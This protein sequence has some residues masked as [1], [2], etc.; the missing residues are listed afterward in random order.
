MPELDC[1]IGLGSNLADRRSFL[2]AAVHGIKRLGRL[3]GL[4]PL[5]ETPPL[6]PPQPDY[7]NAALRLQTALEPAELLRQLLALEQRAG[8]E[9]RER[10]GPRTLDLDILWISG[11]TVDGPGLHVPHPELA[12]RAFALL[13]LLDVAP[14]AFDPGTLSRYA[15]V[16]AQLDRTGVREVPGTRAGWLE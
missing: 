15:E 3:A 7:L 14:E 13:P 4:S 16:A 1:V 12:R 2:V 8:R 9:R 5:Y 10:W 6:G 11:Q